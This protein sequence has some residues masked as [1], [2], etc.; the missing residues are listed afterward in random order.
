MRGARP[1]LLLREQVSLGG[2]PPLLLGGPGRCCRFAAVGAATDTDSAASYGPGMLAPAPLPLESARSGMPK[3]KS[4]SCV[5]AAGSGERGSV[6]LLLS[7]AMASACT[8][9]PGVACGGDCPSGTADSVRLEA[10]SASS[11]RTVGSAAQCDSVVSLV[12]TCRFNENNSVSQLL[13]T[14]IKLSCI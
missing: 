13:I 9:R 5:T 6:A 8:R 14:Y 1:G 12:S 10:S 2:P 3:L 4:A 7:A 11:C